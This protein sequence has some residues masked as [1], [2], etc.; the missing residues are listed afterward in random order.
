MDESNIN[1]SFDDPYNFLKVDDDILDPEFIINNS[2]A[3]VSLF[4]HDLY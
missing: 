2:Y 3:L 4:T 1:A